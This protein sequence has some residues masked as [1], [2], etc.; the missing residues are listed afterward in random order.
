MLDF[1]PPPEHRQVVARIQRTL[2]AMPYGGIAH[3]VYMDTSPSAPTAEAT[4]DQV[5]RFI[6]DNLES[7]RSV[8]HDASAR[9][10]ET[11]RELS[12]I[13]ADLAAVGRLLGRLS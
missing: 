3:F 10:T 2:W 8:L 1:Q 5:L 12:E 4:V 7:L 13:K 9:S 6:A 11:E